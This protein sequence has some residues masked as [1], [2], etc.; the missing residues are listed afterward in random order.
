MCT[1]SRIVN[2][3]TFFFMHQ[4]NHP[5]CM[6]TSTSHPPD[7]N[8][9]LHST[10]SRLSSSSNPDNLMDPRT[11]L[12]NTYYVFLFSSFLL[13]FFL[14]VND[15]RLHILFGYHMNY[16]AFIKDSCSSSLLYIMV[17]RVVTDH[18]LKHLNILHKRVH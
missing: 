10:T 15:T 14:C 6:H 4:I 16:P 5:I 7:K 9:S 3:I 1:R 8:K 17:P 13:F 2:A 11:K 12:R 18:G